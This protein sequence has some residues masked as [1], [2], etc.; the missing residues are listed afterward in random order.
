[1]I[2]GSCA[3]RRLGR[4]SLESWPRGDQQGLGRYPQR[5]LLVESTVV[6]SPV[7]P[8][9]MAVCASRQI[10]SLTLTAIPGFSLADPAARPTGVTG[11]T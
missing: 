10:H 8:V 7:P 5:A 11:A 6:A 4:S 1:V 9:E 2:G 3:R